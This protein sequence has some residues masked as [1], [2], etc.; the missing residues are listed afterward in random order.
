[1][2]SLMFALLVAVAILLFPFLLSL[3]SVLQLTA[4]VRRK[5]PANHYKKV[6]TG[7]CVDEV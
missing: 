4:N 2:I 3:F 6:D 7:D 5:P 1:M